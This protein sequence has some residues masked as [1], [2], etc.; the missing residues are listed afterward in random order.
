MMTLPQIRER[1]M[2]IRMATVKV[3]DDDGTPQGLT[4]LS[5]SQA[6]IN[7]DEAVCRIDKHLKILD[8][9]DVPF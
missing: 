4:R 7:I 9:D 3:K 8:N 1:L 6:I 5:L 2:K